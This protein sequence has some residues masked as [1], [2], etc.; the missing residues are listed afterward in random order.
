M[1]E[2]ISLSHNINP[3][4][5]MRFQLII[6]QFITGILIVCLLS[7]CN[8]YYSNIHPVDTSNLADTELSEKIE[9][10]A[11]ILTIVEQNL[12]G[13][14]DREKQYFSAFQSEKPV[15]LD[16]IQRQDIKDIWI[17]YLD[18]VFVLTKLMLEYLDY[19]EL[20]PAY[21][22]D[23]FVL[24]FSSYLMLVSSG[25]DF[26]EKT[27][28]IAPFEVLLD[29]PI[30]EY[31]IP[32]GLYT[33][34]KWQIL[35]LNEYFKINEDYQKYKILMTEL[36]AGSEQS[37]TSQLFPL[38]ESHYS[39]S[40]KILKSKRM[41]LVFANYL[42][43]IKD[44]SLKMVFPIQKGVALFMAHT[45]FT[46][47]R[48]GFISN[49]QCRQFIQ[50]AE[51][52]DIIL[53]RGEWRMTNLGIP[54]FWPHS[55]LYLGSPSE[56]E[57][58]SDTTEITGYYQRKDPDCSGFS[59]FLKR[60]YPKA[61][62]AYILGED[63]EENQIIEGLKEGI[64]FHSVFGSVGKAD[65]AVC[66]RPRLSKLAKAQAIETAF[67]YWGRGYDYTFSL[68]S[69]NELVCSELIYKSY[70]PAT[71]KTGLHFDFSDIA[72]ILTLPANN[73]AAQFDREY[74]TDSAQL[75]FVLYYACDV[76]RGKSQSASVDSFRES[77]KKP[78]WSF[79]IF[80]N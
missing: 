26:I 12:V 35:N 69:D 36:S 56:L 38:V 10:D 5:H 79:Y 45:R 9:T 40:Q 27:A 49:R 32:R 34:F 47:R 55:A 18:Q 4:K 17:Q 11:Q 41:S 37:L 80:N 57:T 66:L 54:G 64:V 77:H 68:L 16:H 53:E 48:E 60:K 23:A 20:H 75:E 52:G 21:Q 15:L 30:P 59:D 3:D 61:Y 67:Q 6:Q 1:K 33:K 58:W 51:P 65:H 29:E 76:R 24:G 28:F 2:L 63:N 50:K 8:R 42:E 14:Q 31:N 72:G 46:T 13:I 19:P 62:S 43:S 25:L 22:N 73:I 74:G 78:R 70:E 39:Q 7:G 71:N 44:N